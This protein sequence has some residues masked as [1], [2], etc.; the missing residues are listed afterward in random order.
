MKVMKK[1]SLFTALM[2]L[3]SL[4]AFAQDPPKKKNTTATTKAEPAPVAKPAPAP[5]ASKPQDPPK[6]TVPAKRN[7]MKPVKSVGTKANPAPTDN[8]TNPP[9][10]K[11]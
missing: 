4:T 2:F 11:R 7:K 6:N 10:D 1:L 3:V 5:D 8:K 9:S